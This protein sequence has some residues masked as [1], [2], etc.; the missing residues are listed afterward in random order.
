MVMGPPDLITFGEVALDIILVGVD[1]VPR[2]W[3]ILGNARAAR[4]VPAGSAGYVA[5]CFSKLGGRASVLGKIGNDNVGRL[6]LDGFRRC[7]VSTENL[8]VDRKVDTEISTVILYTDGNKSSVVSSILPLTPEDFA[9]ES[10]CSGRAFHFAGFLLYPNLWGKRAISLFRMVRRNGLF[11]SADP[12]MSATRAWAQPFERI[13]EHL[14]VLLLDE[15]EAKRISRRNRIL[16]AVESLLND[17]PRIVAVKSGAKGC[18]VGYGDRIHHVRAYKAK[19]VSTIGAGDA[20]DA[21]FIFGSLKNWSV[22]K[23][24]RF[25]NVVAAVSTTQYGCM[26]AI[27]SAKTAEMLSESYCLRDRARKR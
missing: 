6:V 10:F 26:T 5:Q 23:T 15:E 18:T 13:L 19:P 1:K 14:D 24:A 8:I 9:Q 11:V 25:A 2:R 4:A 16:D 3:S 21:A 20:F 17:G 12:Q 22:E 27:P 7:A